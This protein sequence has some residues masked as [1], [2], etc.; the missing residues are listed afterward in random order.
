MR[1]SIRRLA[2]LIFL[3]SIFLLTACGANPDDAPQAIEA[4]LDALVAKDSDRLAAS[5]CADW[6]GE[7]TRELDMFVAITPEL[8]GV[9]CQLDSSEGEVAYVTCTGSIAYTY[10][11]EAEELSLERR[12][13]KVV[14]EGGD[15]R[16]CGY[17]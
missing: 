9:S 4:Y 6:E 17:K 2:I 3:L 1:L 16:M 5:S 8:K 7:V 11:G 15:W 14:F 12:T 13:Y 10:N